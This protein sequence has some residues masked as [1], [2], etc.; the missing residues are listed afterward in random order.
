MIFGKVNLEDY[1]L[2]VRRILRNSQHKKD[3]LNLKVGQLIYCPSDSIIQF[4]KFEQNGAPYN[5]ELLA[6]PIPTKKPSRLQRLI[7]ALTWK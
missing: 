4:S 6:K 3:V 2:K 5:L 7:N 1:D